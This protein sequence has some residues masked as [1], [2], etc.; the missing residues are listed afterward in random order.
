MDGVISLHT[1]DPLRQLHIFGFL[2]LHYKKLATTLNQL[3]ESESEAFDRKIQ[4][5]KVTTAKESIESWA[6]KR[7]YPNTIRYAVFIA[8][9]SQ[10]EFYVNETCKE[11]GHKQTVKPSDLKGQGLTRA[12]IYLKKVAGFDTPFSQQSWQR[13][14][15]IN[16]LRNLIVHANGMIETENDIAVT[17]R[18]DAWAPIEVRDSKV[19]LSKPFIKNVSEMLHSSAREL[20]DQLKSSGWK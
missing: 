7:L 6:L 20:F 19:I 3:L 4:K 2:A 5:L 18:I 14:T 11:L 10:F 8:I 9:Y 15:D 13:L 1:P 12:N 17:K 16:S